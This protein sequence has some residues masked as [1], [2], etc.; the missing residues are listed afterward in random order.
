MS[1]KTIEMS[2]SQFKENFG[3]FELIFGA[4][5]LES[6]ECVLRIFKDFGGFGVS[7]GGWWAD[8]N[9]RV[10]KGRQCRNHTFH[11]QTWPVWDPLF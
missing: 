10:H 2:D 6:P 1:K 4:T 7:L 8:C 5:F 9:S 11:G 3:T